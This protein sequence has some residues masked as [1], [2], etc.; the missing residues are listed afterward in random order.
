MV[1]DDLPEERAGV[2]GRGL[3][4]LAEGL[5]LAG[6]VLMLAVAC[7]VTASVLMRWLLDE[8][9]SGDFE[10]VQISTAVAAFSFLPLCQA[11]RGNIIVDSF[12]GRLPR[13]ARD[14][15]DAVWDIVYGIAAVLIA[16]HL[17]LGAR[18]S[19]ASGTTSMVRQLPI[20]Y[21]V[22]ACSAMA[23]VLAAVAFVTATRL[24]KGSR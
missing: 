15:L 14:L 10:I 3:R 8:G 24:A 2:L 17:L 18:D 9:I 5:A 7:L 19:L 21:A 4:A 16:W 1:S 23:A 11:A 6:G 13:R 12:T 22:A 20:G